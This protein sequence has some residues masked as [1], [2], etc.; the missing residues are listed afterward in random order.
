MNKTKKIDVL[1]KF[2]LFE[3]LW[4]PKVISEINDF[5]VKLV[6]LKGEFVWHSHDDTDEMF[7]VI[8]GTFQ[9][10]F[11]ER[12][13]MLNKGQIIVIPKGVEHCP[14]ADEMCLVMIFE[15]KGVIN[16]GDTES[17]LRANNDI[18]I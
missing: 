8:D 14:V 10:K 5:Q 4:S 6:R 17:N 1:D 9:M 15:P 2:Q 3:D 18:W 12:E 11:R 16:T 7:Y 13:E